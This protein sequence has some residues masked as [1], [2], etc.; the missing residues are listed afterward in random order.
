MGMWHYLKG[1]TQKGYHKEY[2][3]KT[4]PFYIIFKVKNMKD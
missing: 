4:K 3:F 2:F 1:K